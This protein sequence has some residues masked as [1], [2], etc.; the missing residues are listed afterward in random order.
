VNRY[1]NC[2]HCGRPNCFA[3]ALQGRFAEVRCSHCRRNFG[4]LPSLKFTDAPQQSPVDEINALCEDALLGR[5]E[6]LE[7]YFDRCREGQQG[8]NTKEFAW[9]N[10]VCERLEGEFKH[11]IKRWR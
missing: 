3:P 2:P 11:K 5:K 6:H 4:L 7:S 10:H 9:Y 1:F 8:I